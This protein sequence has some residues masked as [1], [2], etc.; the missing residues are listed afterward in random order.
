[1]KVR[2]AGAELALSLKLPVGGTQQITL[3]KTSIIKSSPH[4]H[5]TARCKLPFNKY[6]NGLS[7]QLKRPL[8]TTLVKIEDRG[9][10][11]RLDSSFLTVTSGFVLEDETINSI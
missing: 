6:I 5:E 2:R 1:M 10:R 11:T 4:S 8:H 7:P 9:S 3:G